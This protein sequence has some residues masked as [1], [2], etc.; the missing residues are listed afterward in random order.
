[1]H[2]GTNVSTL[3]LV[4][5]TLAGLTFS[6]SPIRENIWFVGVAHSGLNRARACLGH[7]SIWHE[8]AHPI[9][10]TCLESPKLWTA[11]T[12]TQKGVSLPA[13]RSPGHLILILPSQGQGTEKVQLEQKL[14]LSL[15]F[16]Y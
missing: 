5:L 8:L 11:A 1:M 4:N 15:S 2:L 3:A 9:W 12:W 13:C 10:R 6:S 7:P 16:F 14:R